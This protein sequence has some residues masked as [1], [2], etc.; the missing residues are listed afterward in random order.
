MRPASRR[1]VPLRAGADT[2]RV[3]GT[4][5]NGGPNIDNITIS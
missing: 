2:V 3:T 1:T 4:T 5:A